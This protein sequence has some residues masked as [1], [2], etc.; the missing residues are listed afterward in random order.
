MKSILVAMDFSAVSEKALRHAVVVARHYG[1]KLYL[2]HVVSSLG[3]TMA[4]PD[5]V[6]SAS[7]LAW[8]DLRTLE[9]RL[10]STGAVAGLDHQAI[11]RDGEIWEQ[12]D[13]VVREKHIEMIVVGTHSRAGIA[14]FVLG[15]AAEQIFRRAS[16]PV[17]TVG[18]CCPTKP[19]LD[20]PELI[21]PVLFPTDFSD[22]SLQA[23]PHAVSFAN[24]QK[25]RLVLLHIL[26]PVPETLDNRWYT[27]EDVI[28]IRKQARQ[29]CLDRLR[30]L[31]ANFGL[32]V[33]PICMA[34]FGYGDRADV[35][36]RAAAELGVEGIIM[37]LKRKKHI[38]TIAHLPW[39]T[40]YK[41]VCGACSAVL[42]VRAR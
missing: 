11:I 3:F 6:T 16:C 25:T 22:E 28:Q 42:T 20:A 32:A 7:E 4:G 39:S 10:E 8:R 9:R 19:Q 17:L 23:L 12:I 21:R 13:D 34:E 30:G 36:I 27:A 29:D 31:V 18:P 26:S 35:I 33:D 37:G 5:S 2:M 40:A 15:S 14:K 38:D 41:V 24:E 1:S